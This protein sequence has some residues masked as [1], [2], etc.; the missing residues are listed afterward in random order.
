MSRDAPTVS[1]EPVFTRA[2]SVAAV[3]EGLLRETERSVDAALY[4]LSHPRLAEAL[5][6]AARREATVRLILDR[7][8][9]EE[10]AATREL[11][12]EFRLPIQLLSGGEE[13]KLH[14][15]FAILDRRIVLAGSYN[16]TLESEQN[17]EN[18]LIIRDENVAAAFQAEFDGLWAAASVKERG[19]RP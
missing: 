17:F 11:A 14:H 1:V 19:A 3:I 4:R 8:K 13:S 15:K 16:W 9:F 2:R 5:A 10:T 18:L 7:R 12:A 6:R